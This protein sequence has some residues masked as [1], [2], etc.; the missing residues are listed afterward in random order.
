MDTRTAEYRVL[1]LHHC[2][3][4]ATVGP[5]NFTFTTASDVIRVRDVPGE[6]AVV[7]SGHIHRHQVITN[8]LRG[9]AID[10]PILYPGSIERTSLAE[11]DETKGFMLLNIVTR[12]LGVPST[13]LGDD[14]QE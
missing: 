5:A 4:G 12:C 13:S 7:L 8:D 9:R 10:T 3:E 11:I 6:F 1:C 2:V 14:S